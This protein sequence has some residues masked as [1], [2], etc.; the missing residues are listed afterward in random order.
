MT[1]DKNTS[2]IP[3]GSNGLVRVGNSI[4]ITNKIISEHEER[5]LQGL[6]PTVK[7]GNQQWMSKNLDVDCYANGDPIPQV[8]NPKEWENLKTGA[9]CYYNN[10]PENGKF[11]G[12]LYNWYVIKD[13][14]GIAPLGFKCPA[15]EDWYS[16][17][18]F[19]E[20]KNEIVKNSLISKT[21]WEIENENY[22]SMN[23]NAK[24]SGARDLN[25]TYYTLG[26]N[27]YWWTSS[28]K[29]INESYSIFIGSRIGFPTNFFL[30][31]G[32]GF[33]IRLIKK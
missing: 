17:F 16:L 9:W 13:E 20:Q 12:K 3:S 4:E 6:Y 24:S 19:I 25:G 30:D 22:N 10:D 18:S 26:I 33:S 1:D 28:E 14:R 32:N 31:K 2:L 15:L 27:A 29:N 11:F 7:I 8:Q 21:G 5:L 23:F